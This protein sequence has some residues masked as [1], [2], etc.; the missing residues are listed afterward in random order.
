MCV[1]G[2]PHAMPTHDTNA[3]PTPRKPTKAPTFRGGQVGAFRKPACAS[4]RCPATLLGARRIN[5]LSGVVSA[6]VSSAM[7][8]STASSFT[9]AQFDG[10]HAQHY[11]AAHPFLPAAVVVAYLLMVWQLP[12]YMADRPPFQLRTVSRCWNI[13]VAV[14]SICGAGVCVPHLLN[15][16]RAHGLWYTVCADVYEL[17]GFGPPAVWAAAFT[18]SKLFELFDTALLILKKRPVITLHW[19]HHASVIGFAWSAWI[20]ETPAAL[21]YGA[22]N[23]SVHAIMYT[24][25]A[26]TAVP[27]YRASVLKVAPI[28]TGL[29]ISQFAWGTVINAI[30]AV[31]YAQPD[32]GC[33]IQ[34]AI[35][36]LAAGLYL[37]YGALFVHLFVRRYVRKDKKRADAVQASEDASGTSNGHH[38][39]K[40]YVGGGLKAV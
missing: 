35:L 31:A 23:Y 26:L 25:F 24:Y 30:A 13:G 1:V 33:A 27:Q 32:V 17:A 28:I 11:F 5:A 8:T 29:Q 18:W 38:G 12:K 3:S 4:S 39:G 19:F 21:W 15:Q 37:A 22:M 16:L 9:Y 6:P 34:P 14:F 2:V 40:N 10:H 7:A 36:Y 20:Y